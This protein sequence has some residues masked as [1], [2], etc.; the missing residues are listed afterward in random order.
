MSNELKGAL[1]EMRAFDGDLTG[2]FRT[3]QSGMQ[4]S[5][6]PEV[7]DEWRAKVTVEGRRPTRPW[8]EVARAQGLDPDDPC[9]A[10]SLDTSK[11]MGTN[12]PIEVNTSL[13]HVMGLLLKRIAGGADGAGFDLYSRMDA[14]SVKPFVRFFLSPPSP[15][16]E[17]GRL[18]LH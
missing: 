3:L 16:E 14:S 15:L 9:F 10:F 8:Q 5:S 2:C 17:G 12:G 18:G 6:S 1:A 7:A 11:V 4:A 13:E